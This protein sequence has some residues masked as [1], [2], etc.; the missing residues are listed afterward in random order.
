MVQLSKEQEEFKRQY[1]KRLT[2]TINMNMGLSDKIKMYDLGI[3]VPK[4][5]LRTR[6][7]RIGDHNNQMQ[8]LRENLNALF[9]NDSISVSNAIDYFKDDAADTLFFNQNFKKIYNDLDD[10]IDLDYLT[11]DYFQPFYERFKKVNTETFGVQGTTAKEIAKEIN[12]T[13]SDPNYQFLTKKITAKDLDNN[14]YYINV[15]ANELGINDTIMRKENKQTIINAIN[16]VFKNVVLILNNFDNDDYINGKLHIFEKP[17]DIQ[18]TGIETAKKYAEGVKDGIIPHLLNGDIKAMA[19]QEEDDER[20]RIQQEAIDA[21]VRRQAEEA[22]FKQEEENRRLQIVENIKNRTVE[23]KLKNVASEKLKRMREKKQQEEEQKRLDDERKQQE[24]EQKRQEEEQKRQEEERIKQEKEAQN[25][26][27]QDQYDED[28]AQYEAEQKI[29][30][31]NYNKA[32]KKWEKYNDAYDEYTKEIGKYSAGDIIETDGDEYTFQGASKPF[33][34]S[35]DNKKVLYYFI[36]ETSKKGTM[37]VKSRIKPIKKFVANDDLPQPPE[38]QPQ[39]TIL[40]PPSKPVLTGK[41]FNRNINKKMKDRVN[42][43]YTQN[44]N[45]IEQIRPRVNITG[46]ELMKSRKPT[47]KIFEL[48]D[49]LG[50][51]FKI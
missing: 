17:L 37:K 7:E 40:T 16:D 47:K 11:Y 38:P 35:D 43:T 4:Q 48:L 10:N 22:R 13:T 9:G 2:G 19:Q 28:Y 3:E 27:L 6:T 46:G 39:P 26:A 25:K 32:L 1:M 24:A 5:D 34:I 12:N 15:L 50:Y 51:R 29:E 42:N 49:E 33:F 21:E 31:E 8:K 41:G 20:R 14:M 44:Y 36:H 45:R 30:D 23:E 18:F